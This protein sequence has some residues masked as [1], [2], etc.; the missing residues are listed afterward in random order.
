MMIV[1]LGLACLPSSA[2]QAQRKSS[3]ETKSESIE[4]AKQA[5]TLFESGQAAHQ[6]GALEKAVELYTEALKLDPE[7]WQ[8]EFQRGVAWVS[9]NKFAEAKNSMT[10]VIDQLREFP[11]SNQLRQASSRVQ[12]TLGQ[13]ATA[14]NSLVEAERAFRSALELNPQVARAR[15]GLAEILLKAGKA[16]E[17]AVEAKTAIAEGDNNDTTYSLLGVAQMQSGKFDDALL[18]FGEALKRDPKN[19]FALRHRAEVLVAKNRLG[20]ASAALRSALAIEPNVQTKLKLAGV[21]IQ[22]RQF[23]EAIPVYQEVLNADPSNVE[24][25]AALAAVMIESGKGGEAVTQLESLI[26]T[27]PN[28]AD[29]RAQLAEL[30]LPTQPEKALEQYDAASRLEPSQPSHQIGLASALVKLRRFQEAVTLLQKVIAQNPKDDLAYFAHT[31]LAVALFELDDFQNAAREFI[32]ILDYQRN[33]G[34]QKRAA[35]TIYFLGICFDKLGDYE[36]ALK[37]YEQFLAIASADNQLEID[38]VKLRLPSLHKQI[39]EGKGKRK[40]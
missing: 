9:L 3:A 28:R 17:A 10:R 15:I 24:A 7:L 37:A 6:N 11:D 35:V 20:E 4:Q 5:E 22:A 40:Q 18:S 8:A 38:K 12:I 34:D 32:R 26:K 2:Q 36:Q 23:S 30:Y 16:D 27:D 25:R 21:Y 31:N 39:K 13:I 14:E 1:F 33:R 19:V 29:L